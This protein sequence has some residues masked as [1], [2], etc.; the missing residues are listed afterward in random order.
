MVDSLARRVALHVSRG[1][2]PKYHRVFLKDDS[3]SLDT[4]R[5]VSSSQHLEALTELV[6]AAATGL[7]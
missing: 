6:S 7:G 3:G 2:R 4:P 1:E 5:V